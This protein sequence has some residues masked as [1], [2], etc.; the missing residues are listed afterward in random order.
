MNLLDRP[1]GRGSRGEFGS[2][3]DVENTEK[4][5]IE[6]R[7]EHLNS[8][9]E[10]IA[11]GQEFQEAALSRGN[12]NIWSVEGSDGCGKSTILPLVYGV[13]EEKFS[14]VGECARVV[15]DGTF[16]RHSGDD[17]HRFVARVLQRAALEDIYAIEA[18]LEEGAISDERPLLLENSII[19]DLVY[20]LVR[21]DY[22]REYL[23]PF[24]EMIAKHGFP[25]GKVILLTVSPETSLER[26]NSRGELGKGDPKDLEEAK[27]R[28]YAYEKMLGIIKEHFEVELITVSNNE[29]LSEDQFE[30]VMRE[31][32]RKKLGIVE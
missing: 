6:Q 24:R 20:N 11:A 32:L 10:A 7:L 5:A 15:P 25:V 29:E 23:D 31:K 17:R 8:E 9:F 19:R 3:G 2:E 22:R 14:E 16:A 4:P 18:K 30:T 21:P 26:I 1:D 13:L 12:L 27:L 28:V